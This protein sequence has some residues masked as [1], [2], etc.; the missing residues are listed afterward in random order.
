MTDYQSLLRHL[1]G[2]P[3]V[4]YY[5][6]LARHVGGAK[7]AVLLSQ[8]LYLD[9]RAESPGAW[10]EAT[11][12]NIQR[13]TGLSL[14]EQRSARSKLKELRLI[15]CK[16]KGMPSKYHYR[17]SLEALAGL[18]SGQME[19]P[20]C[21]PNVHTVVTETSSLKVPKGPDC[22]DASGPSVLK[23]DKKK[24]A[25]KKKNGRP[26]A[27][28]LHRRF[29]NRY[30]NKRQWSAVDRVVGSDFPALLRWGRIVRRWCLSDYNPTNAKGMLQVFKNG[31]D[32]EQDKDYSA[33]DDVARFNQGRS[34]K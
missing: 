5:G 20:Q 1:L 8:L 4:A 26:P 34:K 21:D 23:R 11:V 17:V 16:R 31:W 32:N 10:F 30:L 29:A 3:I 7:N 14:R 22:S 2:A 13:A 24:E 12:I 25:S 33:A 6:A 15:E 9:S 28:E 27:V 18:V 19:L